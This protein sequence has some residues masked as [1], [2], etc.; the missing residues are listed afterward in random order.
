MNRRWKDAGRGGRG[1]KERETARVNVCAG[2]RANAKGRRGRGQGRRLDS[3]GES[4]RTFSFSPSPVPQTLHR[5]PTDAVDVVEAAAAPVDR[6][7]EFHAAECTAP[8]QISN[9][10]SA[11]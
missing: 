5:R 11:D 7:V 1:E 4:G 6:L 3:A 9:Q 10:I 8:R 2:I